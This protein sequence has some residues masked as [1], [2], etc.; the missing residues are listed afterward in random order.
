[1]RLESTVIYAWIQSTQGESIADSGPSKLSPVDFYM[2]LFNHLRKLFTR[3]RIDP[4]PA[5]Q[6]PRKERARKS[7]QQKA[8]E[9]CP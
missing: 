2:C 9:G 3:P 1:M 4:Q 7:G 5:S 6:L 8:F